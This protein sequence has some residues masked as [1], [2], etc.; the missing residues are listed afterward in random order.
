MA[1]TFNMLVCLLMPICSGSS[2]ASAIEARSRPE[3]P[4]KQL[5]QP[6]V[7]GRHFAFFRIWKASSQLASPPTRELQVAAEGVFDA[8]A[9]AATRDTE[10]EGLEAEILE[11]QLKSQH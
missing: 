1:L 2:T 6:W 10:M 4:R 8:D 11:A 9:T 3:T 5:L 7:V